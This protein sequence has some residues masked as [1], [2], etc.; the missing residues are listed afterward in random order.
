MN[1]PTWDLDPKFDFCEEHRVDPDKKVSLKDT[2]TEME[3]PFRGKAHGHAFTAKAVAEIQSLQYRTFV[4]GQQ[5]LVIV[6]QALDAGGKDGLIRKVLGQM[7]PQGCRTFP[8]KAPSSEELDH[9]FLWRIHAAA[10]AAGK[11][12]IFNRSHYE[13]VLAVRVEKL[14]PKSI[15]KERYELINDF[16]ALLAHRSTRVLKFYLHISPAEQ[17]QRFKKRLDDPSKHWK[18]N[19]GDYATRDQW[20]EYRE[21]YEDV[22]EKCNSKQAPWYI[23]PADKK[24]YRDASVAAIVRKTFQDMDPQLPAV[25]VDIDRIRKLYERAESSD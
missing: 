18:L 13:D 17:L 20:E 24:W 16:E 10:P 25:D 4:E 7:N 19:A 22:F 1:L 3:G 21:A 9:D 6:L 5:S 2:A 11:V 14:A 12:S 15:W 23:I 8:F